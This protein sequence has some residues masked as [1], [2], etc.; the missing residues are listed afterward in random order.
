MSVW[1]VK[2]KQKIGEIIPSFHM[3]NGMHQIHI[4][5]KLSRLSVVRFV[6]LFLA[7]LASKHSGLEMEM[8]G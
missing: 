4:A 8:A 6:C 5:L 3:S 7:L 1:Y 2:M